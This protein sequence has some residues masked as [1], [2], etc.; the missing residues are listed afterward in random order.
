MYTYPVLSNGQVDELHLRNSRT[1]FIISNLYDSIQGLHKSLAKSP[2]SECQRANFC[3]NS[4]LS[5]TL[6]DLFLN[7]HNSARLR[8]AKGIEP[9]KTGLLNPAKNMYKLEWDCGLEHKAQKAI[10]SCPSTT[11]PIPRTAQNLMQ[12]MYQG[13]VAIDV[14]ANI[15]STL[16]R[17]WDAAVMFGVTDPENRY[18][19]LL[20]NFA[21]MVFSETTKIGC[22]HQTCR[23]DYATY[24][25]VTCLYNAI[26]YVDNQR[27]WETGSACTN[28]SQCTTHPNS[29]CSGG[30]CVK[31]A[32]VSET[33]KMCPSNAGMTDSV[34]M[35][36]VNLQN[37]FRSSLARGLEPDGLGGKAPKASKMLRMVYD[38]SIEASAMR[39]ARKC[40]FA[41]SK[42]S[43][44][45]GLGENLFMTTFLNFDKIKTAEQASQK[46]WNELKEFGIGPENRLTMALWKRR[47]KK[48]GHYTQMAWDT[49]YKLGCAVVACP[50][51]T[52]G[53][54]Q[55][56][57]KGNHI[58]GQ[59]YT[60]GKPCTGCPHSCN[61]TEGLCIVV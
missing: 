37:T 19:D 36:F 8:V 40:I 45:P 27:L 6:R 59:I 9:N 1:K 58:N 11:T 46:W 3:S 52:F 55:Y 28:H 29:F 18:T 30:L 50:N 61:N 56:G 33:N 17:W 5:N 53:V 26:A 42:D 20:Y 49:S 48:I 13:N 51:F 4:T 32:A 44:R 7:F 39:S 15:K 12:I 31:G 25:S 54:C 24:I 35:A 22:A 47:G 57:P 2:R 34:R 38:C 21:N 23:T 43:E 41:H 16:S 14:G 60:V 10:A